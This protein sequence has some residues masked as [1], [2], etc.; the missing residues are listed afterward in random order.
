M[1]TKRPFGKR[2]NLERLEDRLA[3]AN[4]VF[5]VTALAGEAADTPALVRFEWGSSKA[6]F[7]NEIGAFVVDDVNGSIAG[8]LPSD[9]GY[10]GAALARSQVIFSSGTPSNAPARR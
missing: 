4:D 8:L 1:T 6:G 5:A 7:S 3:P 10:A 9:P 2:L